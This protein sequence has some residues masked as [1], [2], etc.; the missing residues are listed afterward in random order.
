VTGLND[1]AELIR[2]ANEEKRLREAAEIE[3]KKTEVAPLLSEL[4]GA[5]AKA[6]EEKQEIALT[7]APLLDEL[8]TALADPESIKLKKEETKQQIVA[9]VQQV[10]EK[11]NSISEIDIDK[12]LS[13]L[14]EKFL[15]LYKKLSNEFEV[16]KKV[17]NSVSK[18]TSTTPMWGSTS[19]SGE[20]R[21]TRM[22]DFQ[23]E[24]LVNGAALVW[25]SVLKKF[26]PVV[27]NTTGQTQQIT[28]EEMPFSKRVDFIT[29]DVL[30]RGEAVVGASESAPLWRI[31]QITIGADNDV[32][33]LWAS[34]SSDYNKVWANRANYTY[35]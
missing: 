3:R 14:D 23:N 15:S 6:K 35:S 32:T 34:G 8:R 25:D 17:L 29:D 12:K 22:D 27:L 1:F 7:E 19:G 20:V 21:I 2:K 10:E 24:N 9:L 31:R 5:V 4:F 28:D 11:A 33:E 26:K 13:E 18:P 30:Y 16:L